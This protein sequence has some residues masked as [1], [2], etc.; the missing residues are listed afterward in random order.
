MRG[1][2]AHHSHKMIVTVT[3]HDLTARR[4]LRGAGGG[5]AFKAEIFEDLPPNQH[6]WM[7]FGGNGQI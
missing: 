4:W 1:D 2:I 7:D 6:L 3:V 5:G